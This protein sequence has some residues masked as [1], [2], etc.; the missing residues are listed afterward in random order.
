MQSVKL[1]VVQRTGDK[2]TV[3]VHRTLPLTENI[4]KKR[5]AEAMRGFKGGGGSTACVPVLIDIPL[6]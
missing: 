1:A 2:S 6:R 5:G 3:P 4:A